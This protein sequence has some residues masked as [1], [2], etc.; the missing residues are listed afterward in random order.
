MKQLSLNLDEP[1]ALHIVLGKQDVVTLVRFFAEQAKGLSSPL[2]QG[3]LIA[4]EPKSGQINLN[5]SLAVPNS[6][7][8]LLELRK[9][10]GT[11]YSLAGGMNEIPDETNDHQNWIK[12]LL[13]KLSEI[14]H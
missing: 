1:N 5:I 7:S 8:S 9:R 12:K 13:E 11:R 6:S 14:T 2:A 4:S 3:F 10:L